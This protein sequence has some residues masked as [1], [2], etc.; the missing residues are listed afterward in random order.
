MPSHSALIANIPEIEALAQGVL[1]E[2]GSAL[3]AVASGYFCAAGMFPGVLLSEAALMTA[4]LGGN[5]RVFDGRLRQP[6]CAAKRPRGFTATDCIPEAALV[7]APRAV[8]AVLIALAYEKGS[9]PSKVVQ[10]GVKA[11]EQARAKQRA[12]ALRR[13]AAVGA[14]AFAE[15]TIAHPLLAVA[16]ASQGGALTLTDLGQVGELD[17]TGRIL[18]KTGDGIELAT[19]WEASTSKAAKG[20]SAPV[21]IVAVDGHGRFAALCAEQALQGMPIDEL[22]LLAPFAAKP[23]MRGVPKEPPG[24]A[25]PSRIDLRVRLTREGVP[26]EIEAKLTSYGKTKA[27]RFALRQ[28]ASRRRVERLAAGR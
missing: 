16:G 1:V 19:P 11:A 8:Q 27:G 23:V 15:S 9:T 25:L 22:E 7:A 14:G 12:K 6:G 20:R 28:D 3:A 18:S 21:V 5:V 10:V 4:V 13:I 17:T 24:S 26:F 2:T